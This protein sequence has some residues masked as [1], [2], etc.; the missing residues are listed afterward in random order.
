MDATIKNI[1]RISTMNG[2]IQLQT[3]G[4]HLVEQMNFYSAIQKAESFLN[5]NTEITSHNKVKHQIC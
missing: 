1:K 2:L 4:N 5:H 3:G